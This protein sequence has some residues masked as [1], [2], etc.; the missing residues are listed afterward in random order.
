MEYG[1]KW[2]IDK[3][4]GVPYVYTNV[5]LKRL[6]IIHKEKGFIIRYQDSSSHLNSLM[7]KEI[8]YL[9]TYSNHLLIIT[10]A[11]V[12]VSKLNL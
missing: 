2:T 6:Y 4:D 8:L 10:K 3:G 7:L 1:T 5:C 9:F 11:E 12:S